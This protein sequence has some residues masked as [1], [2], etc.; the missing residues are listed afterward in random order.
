MENNFNDLTT[1]QKKNVDNVKIYLDAEGVGTK[2]KKWLTL[3]TGFASSGNCVGP[4]LLFGRILSDSMPGKKIAFIKNA[5]SGTPLGTT[6]GWLP[7]S[8]NNGTGGTLYKNMMTTIDNA[9][10]TFNTAY[11]TTL[12]IPRWAGF[13]WLQGESDAMDQKLTDK[14]EINLT[15]LIKDIR[16]KTGVANLPVIIPM[17]DVQDFWTFA[18]KVRAA[19]VAV[20][21]KLE[22]VDTMDTKGLPTNK[23]HYSAK[24][25]ATIGTTCA[26][27]WLA[28][29]YTK[30]WPSWMTSVVHQTTP[31]ASSLQI[32]F[33]P[34]NKA[35]FNL[36]GRMIGASVSN[37]LQRQSSTLMIINSNVSKSGNRQNSKTLD[38]Q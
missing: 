8:S 19:E 5:V 22:N 38:L 7:P 28:M 13:V 3:G 26:I 2:M 36:S 6:A 1:D 25:Q 33:S 31:A 17:I 30:D 12:Y 32:S 37:Q 14:Y 10:K 27:R 20:K 11:D 35:Q 16:S 15:N 23:I 29:K 24:G 21:N 18:A 34:S 9:L 4:E